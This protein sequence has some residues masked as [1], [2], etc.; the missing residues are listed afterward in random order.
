MM[1]IMT[2]HDDHDENYKVTKVIQGKELILS[3]MLSSDKSQKVKIVFDK[4][5]MV[6]DVLP[7][8]MFCKNFVQLYQR[9]KLNLTANLQISIY[10]ATALP[11]FVNPPI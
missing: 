8:A 4:E 7:V 5:G 1:T 6:C 11:P 9:V 3:K 10:S 2:D